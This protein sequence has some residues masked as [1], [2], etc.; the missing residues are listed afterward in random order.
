MPE[1]YWLWPEPGHRGIYKGKSRHRT[2]F[3]ARR[4]HVSALGIQE[5]PKCPV[6]Q[7]LYSHSKSFWNV[8]CVPKQTLILWHP[9]SKKII[10]KIGDLLFPFGFYLEA[11]CHPSSSFLVSVGRHVGR[12]Q[13][14][15]P[16]VVAS[17]SHYSQSSA[18]ALGLRASPGQGACRGPTET[19]GAGISTLGS[20]TSQ[21]QYRNLWLCWCLCSEWPYL[22]LNSGLIK[23][24]ME[25]VK[26]DQNFLYPMRCLYKAACSFL[27]TLWVNNLSKLAAST[28]TFQEEF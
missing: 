17:Q 23:P 14:G 1:E 2:H 27:N 11:C 26:S 8:P 24:S 15:K 10:Q 12:R 20:A 25:S 22:D 21:K 4:D 7:E 3:T 9:E 19:W 16:G 18:V 6:F 5:L 13:P 28:R